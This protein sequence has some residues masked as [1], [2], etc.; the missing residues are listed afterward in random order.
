[1][2]ISIYFYSSDIISLSIPV[3][4]LFTYNEGQSKTTEL[5]HISYV[6]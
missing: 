5:I 2:F 1:M 6:G 4:L 3:L